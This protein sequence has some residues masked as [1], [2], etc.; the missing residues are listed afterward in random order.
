MGCEPDLVSLLTLVRSHPERGLRVT[1]L[2]LGGQVGSRGQI[3]KA[4]S[5]VGGR[6]PWESLGLCAA[7]CA[8]TL[9]G[10][11]SWSW[12]PGKGKL[13]GNVLGEIKQ[14]PQT[15]QVFGQPS[16]KQHSEKR[17]NVVGSGEPPGW[18]EASGWA[19]QKS[20]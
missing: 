2:T 14:L 19:A 20:S 15:R 13:S 8:L 11:G 6:G 9:R 10:V 7:G 17:E 16:G 4:G 1:R 12:L 5:A 18:E 3:H